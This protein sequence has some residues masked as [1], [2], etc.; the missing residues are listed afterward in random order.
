MSW[1]RAKSPGWAAFDHKQRQKEGFEVEIDN[2]PYPPVSSALTPLRPYQSFVQNNNLPERSFSSML[3][4]EVKFPTLTDDEDHKMPLVVGNS[5]ATKSNKFADETDILQAY[6]ILKAIHSW[7]DESLIEDV[8][9]AVD[10]NGNKASDLLTAMVSSESFEQN[11][12]KN[13]GESESKSGHFPLDH[14]KSLADICDSFGQATDLTEL[15]CINDENEELT[16]NLAAYGNRN[17]DNAAAQMK[18]ILGQFRSIPV[19]PEWEEDDIYLIHRKDAIRMMRSASQHSRAATDAYLRGDHFSAQQFSV[20][21]REEWM[22]AERLNAKAAK[23]ILSI[24]NSKNDLW[25]LDLH[26]LHAV[27]AVQALQERLQKLESLPLDRSASPDRKSRG[28]GIVRSASLEFLSCMETDKLDAQRASSQQRPTSLDVITG[29]GNHSRGQAALPTA[30]KNFLNENGY[31]YDEA[32]PGLIT[33]RPKF[34][35]R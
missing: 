15:V 31:H 21:A 33:V 1:R 32:R 10:N 2:E 25:K 4:P 34:R 22:T 19:E 29:R 28:G 14:K 13:I 35:R 30:V 27:E 11:K 12:D 8:M 23:E 17:S 7:A 5:S 24:R 26:G 16:N 20:K 3:Y 6:D 9:T 18:L